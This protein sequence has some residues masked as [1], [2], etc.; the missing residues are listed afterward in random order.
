[1]RGMG[2]AA[3]I[4]M[5]GNRDGGSRPALRLLNA[6]T[7][8]VLDLGAAGRDNYYGFG[9]VQSYKAVQVLVGQ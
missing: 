5:A 7:S 9:L 3:V 1:M 6:L 2:M 8:T 4:G